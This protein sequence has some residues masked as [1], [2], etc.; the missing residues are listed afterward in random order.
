MS[1]KKAV[2]GEGRLRLALSGPSGSGKTYTALI[3][4]TALAK[5]R[6]AVIDTERGAASKYADRFDFDVN[7]LERHSP[8]DYC[9][10]IDEAVGDGVYDVL[11]IDSLSHEWMGRGGALEM[12]DQAA[13]DSRSGNSFGAWRTVTPKHNKLV[14]ALTSAPMHV[15]ATMR[16]KTE[17]VIEKDEKGKSTPRKVGTAAVQRDGMEYEFDVTG[18]MTVEN[19]LYVTKSRCPDLSGARI[20]QPGPEVAQQ[21]AAWLKGDVTPYGNIVNLMMAAKTEAELEAAAR[22]A[23]GLD[24]AAKNRL[25]PI[26][27]TRRDVLRKLSAATEPKAEPDPNAGAM[28]RRGGTYTG[29]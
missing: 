11:V 7:E 12:V 5:K 14:D 13:S 26:Y 22:L 2:K 21:L 16:S 20:E 17:W 10:A 29:D 9:K 1:F 23:A 28:Q 18:E 24:A 6:V 4:A 27:S 8:Y 19:V 3:F 25:K 15:I